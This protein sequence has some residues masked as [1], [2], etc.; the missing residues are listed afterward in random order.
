MLKDE[1]RAESESRLF[2]QPKTPKTLAKTAW[3][4]AKTRETQPKTV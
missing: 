3:V 1:G 4:C 2:V